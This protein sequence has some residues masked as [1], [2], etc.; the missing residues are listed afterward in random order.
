M[1][2]AVNISFDVDTNSGDVTNVTCKV[3]GQTKKRV[4]TKK[5]SEVLEP[6][7]IID[8]VDNRLE[9]NNKAIA[10]LS[11]EAGDRV[12]ISYEKIGGIL[13]PMISK[14]DTTGN[15]LSKSNTVAFRGAQNDVLA[16]F[17]DQFTLEKYKEDLYKLIPVAESAENPEIPNVKAEIII[18]DN[19]TKVEIDEITFE[20]IKTEQDDTTDID[21]LQFKL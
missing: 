4:T 2:R 13:K 16:E 6:Y 11:L 20:D 7:S 1:I 9:L 21:V 8:R 17:G 19:S 10:E 15:K 3:E 12:N 18:D 5:K 14:S